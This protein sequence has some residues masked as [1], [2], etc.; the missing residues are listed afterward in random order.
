MPGM[1]VQQWDFTVLHTST[2]PA[3]GAVGNVSTKCFGTIMVYSNPDYSSTPPRCVYSRDAA[4][5]TAGAK[6]GREHEVHERARRGFLARYVYHV[7]SH[8]E[9]LRVQRR[10][11]VKGRGD[12]VHDAPAIGEGRELGMSDLSGEMSERETFRGELRCADVQ[13]AVFPWM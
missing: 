7:L 4:A 3:P 8:G 10:R 12:V 13:R 2:F 6:H 11:D 9:L 1:R 5:W